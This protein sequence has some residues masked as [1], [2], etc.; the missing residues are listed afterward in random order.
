MAKSVVKNLIFV[1]AMVVALVAVW[2]VSS[3]IADNPLVLPDV[4]QVC[5]ELGKL[6][7]DVSFYVAVGNTAI[8]A[9]VS[10][11][12]SFVVA[13]CLSLFANLWNIKRPVNAVVTLLRALPTI[14]IILLCLVAFPSK[15]IPFI[16]AIL[17]AFPVMY[18]S[19]DQTVVQNK[20]LLGMCDVFE[21]G[22]FDRIR[23]VML[24]TL[25]ETMFSQ[26]KAALPLCVKVVIAGEALALP[27]SGLGKS[28]Y[29]ARVNVDMATL[30][31]WTLVALVCCYL[32]EL[33]VFAL[34]K[35]YEYLSDRIY[36]KR[37]NSLRGNEHADLQ[38]DLDRT[39]S[40]EEK[41]IG[42]ADNRIAS[43]CEKTD[44]VKTGCVVDDGVTLKNVSVSYG[45][46]V[47]YHNFSATFRG[48]KLHA[49]LGCSGCGKTTLLNVVAGLVSF[50]GECVCGK[51]S[52]VFQE[53]RL[54]PVSVLKNVQMVMSHD[55]CVPQNDVKRAVGVLSDAEIGAQ[56]HRKATTLSGGEQQRVAIA[57]A[58]ACCSDVL[59]LDEPFKS[60]DLKV[61]RRLYSTLTKLLEGNPKTTL[62]VTHDVDEALALADYVYIARGNPVNLQ[63]VATISQPRGCRDL[64]SDEMLSLRRKLE[65]NL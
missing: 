20:D 18:A 57:R 43:T 16:V 33:L 63:L 42:S 25:V 53:P 6:M 32:F 29:V 58:F 30:F 1:V 40:D 46:N 36:S 50:D 10:F 4:A 11:V 26:S 55:G 45:S 44:F 39:R 62:F 2:T 19:F 28:M 7:S 41:Q 23:Y 47:I 9:V 52:Y 38:S 51:T 5:K 3:L 15:S 54:A 31:A 49:V 27:R 8:R 14:S 21:V 24:P 35:S 61:K 17:V 34:R 22:N 12:I 48:G 56:R 65:Q 64:Y 13:L 60:L 59:L 37:I